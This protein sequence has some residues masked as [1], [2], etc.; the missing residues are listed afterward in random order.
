M[1]KFTINDIKTMISKI[2]DGLKSLN[3][4][5]NAA[6]ESLNNVLQ[7]HPALESGFTNLNRRAATFA[8]QRWVLTADHN[9]TGD[10][11]YTGTQTYSGSVHLPAVFVTERELDNKLMQF[12]ACVN[13][14]VLHN[15][16]VLPIPLIGSEL[17]LVKS[18]YEVAD[19]L[20]SNFSIRFS[21]SDTQSFVNGT[22]REY[23]I[24][25]N[26][27]VVGTLRPGVANNYRIDAGAASNF[28]G[29]AVIGSP[30][31]G[32]IALQKITVTKIGGTLKVYSVVTYLAPPV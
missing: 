30:S 25:S 2:G 8:T 16:T 26:S 14:D 17:G 13:Y 9:F 28:T 4:S 1:D 10:I 5:E 7:K 12:N 23:T 21:Y 20:S 31:D 6:L 15:S 18:L 24:V 22:V 19:P 32:C 29:S 3:P 27:P 11:N